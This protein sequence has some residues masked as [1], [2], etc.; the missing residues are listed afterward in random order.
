ML[1]YTHKDAAV[2]TPADAAGMHDI[3]VLEYERGALF[4][5]I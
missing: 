5:T 2:N 4:P 1:M 3:A